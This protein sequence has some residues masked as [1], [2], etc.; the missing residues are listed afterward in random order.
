MNSISQFKAGQAA[1]PVGS[2]EH[3]SEEAA[4]DGG[5]VHHKGVLL[6]VAAVARNGHYCVLACRQLPAA[7]FY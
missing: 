3:G 6:V 5:L 1:H 4:V 2:E 7:Y